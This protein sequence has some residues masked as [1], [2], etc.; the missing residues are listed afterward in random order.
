M[1]WLP[2]ASRVHLVRVMPIILADQICGQVDDDSEA[3]KS[4]GSNYHKGLSLRLCDA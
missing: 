1:P 4:S 2:I 3:G